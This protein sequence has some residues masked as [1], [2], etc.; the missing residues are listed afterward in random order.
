MLVFG[1][2]GL[3]LPRGGGHRGNVNMRPALLE[4]V[5]DT[6]GSVAVLISA[7]VIALTGWERADAVASLVIAGLIVPHSARGPEASGTARALAS[8][9]PLVR[10][11]RRSGG[12]D[13]PRRSLVVLR[14]VPA[15][16][17]GRDRA[18]VAAG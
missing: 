10:G 18:E 12:R 14:S 1:I 2:V 13:M 16:E 9:A 8:P 17:K 15:R 7:V 11:T 3:V 5:N 6:L 4:V